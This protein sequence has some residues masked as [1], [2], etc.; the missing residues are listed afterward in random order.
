[1][2]FAIIEMYCLLMQVQVFTYV[3]DC[4]WGTLEGR[5]DV[6]IVE[7]LDTYLYLHKHV[8]IP[9]LKEC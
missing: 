6:L 8:S 3:E 9:V 4:A 1:M 2:P 5:N 7:G